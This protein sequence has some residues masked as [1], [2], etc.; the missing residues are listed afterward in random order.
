MIKAFREKYIEN[1]FQ[2]VDRQ[3]LNEVQHYL[4]VTYMTNKFDVTYKNF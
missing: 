1:K 4:E 2:D 3:I